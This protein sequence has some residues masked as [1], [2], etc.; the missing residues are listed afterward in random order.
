MQGVISRTMCIRCRLRNGR[1]L[2]V[3]ARAV[4]PLGTGDS[5]RRHAQ[6]VERFAVRD[7]NQLIG[8]HR[9]RTAA[10]AAARILVNRAEVT[11]DGERGRRRV[12]NPR[13]WHPVQDRS[14]IYLANRI[15]RGA[16]GTAIRTRHQ[17]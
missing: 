1:P 12:R 5:V 3:G 13:R 14:T 11:A 16:A 7:I 17:S 10:A 2:L 8:T 9:D 6:I 15:D 4:G